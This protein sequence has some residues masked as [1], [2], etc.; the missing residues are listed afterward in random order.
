MGLGYNTG[1]CQGRGISCVNYMFSAF[2][3]L[4]Y[5]ICAVDVVVVVVGIVVVVSVANAVNVVVVVVDDYG[6]TYLLSSLM[7][8]LTMVTSRI[9]KMMMMMMKI[10]VG[11]NP[12]KCYFSERLYTF[13]HSV[14]YFP[15]VRMSI[16][17]TFTLLR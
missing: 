7:A 2:T 12:S 13:E 6:D 11:Q 14:C 1:Y 8:T 9:F 4:T 5:M 16:L 17:H 3:I 10:K 15:Y